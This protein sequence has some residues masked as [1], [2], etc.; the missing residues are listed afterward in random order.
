[1]I[2]FGSGQGSLVRLLRR[3]SGVGGGSMQ[4]KGR[5]TSTL[6]PQEWN[7]SYQGRLTGSKFHGI[8]R[9]LHF[10]SGIER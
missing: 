3:D 1:M 7:P 5:W 6:G 10:A 8:I 2:L 4:W 9:S